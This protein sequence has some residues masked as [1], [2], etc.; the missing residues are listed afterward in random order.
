MAVI[1][2]RKTSSESPFAATKATKRVDRR[3]AELQ[4]LANVGL[5][6]TEAITALTN[7]L[8]KETAA[9]WA[10]RPGI[11][12]EEF[13]DV[14]LGYVRAQAYV[15]AG[16]NP[17]D[18]KELTEREFNKLTNRIV[19]TATANTVET[20][21]VAATAKALAV[22]IVFSARQHGKPPDEL[23]KFGHDAL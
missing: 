22:L 20:D 19:K 6:E 10:R 12:M 21:A 7:A 23:L 2:W 13:L 5:N 3:T 15:A 1:F 4:R 9:M 14:N 17:E 8:G 11:P 16:L 18:A